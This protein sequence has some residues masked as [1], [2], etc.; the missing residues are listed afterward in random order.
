M[1]KVL[2]AT[3]MALAVS[4]PVF[5]TPQANAAEVKLKL[6]SMLPKKT[7]IGGT[8]NGFIN[9]L[10]EKFKGEFQIDWR[11]GPEVVPQFKQPNT[12]RIGAVD[13]TLTLC[14]WHF[15]RFRRCQL[16]QQAVWRNQ[17][18]RLSRLHDQAACRERPGLCW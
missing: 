5:S 3:T 6:V 13:M 9:R 17:I 1:K 8:F 14:Q 15:E 2:L 10:N 7:A 16:F 12:V 18:H 4:F 11:G